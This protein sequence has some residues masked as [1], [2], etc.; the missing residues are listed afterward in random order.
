MID[1]SNTE[2]V[3]KSKLAFHNRIKSNE[4]GDQQLMQS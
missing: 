3:P 4:A 2:V 1:E